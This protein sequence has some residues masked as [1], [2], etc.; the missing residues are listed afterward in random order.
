MDE[1]ISIK[2]NIG[3]RYYPIK[4]QAVDEEKFRKAAKLINE[5]EKQYRDQ[6]ALKDKQD[7]LAMTALEFATKISEISGNQETDTKISNKLM[8]LQS[9]LND[10]G[11]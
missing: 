1:L 3:D 10:Y 5:V 4:I 11:L 2:I 7:A 9:L 6:F 8:Q